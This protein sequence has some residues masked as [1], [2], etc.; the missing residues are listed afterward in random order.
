VSE[1]ALGP[2]AAQ[3]TDGVISASGAISH[4]IFKEKWGRLTRDKLAGHVRGGSEGSNSSR[5]WHRA[6]ARGLDSEVMER[7]V[8]MCGRSTTVARCGCDD[9]RV[10]RLGCGRWVPCASC[11][12][13]RAH[14]YSERV[15]AA[16]RH[17]LQ[18]TGRRAAVYLVTLTLPHEAVEGRAEEILDAAWRRMMRHHSP[19]GV[20]C[21]A[22][23]EW[24]P[25]RD[26]RGHPHLH[27]V[28]V[29]S[30]LDYERVGA[31]W[32]SAV[33]AVGGQRPGRAGVEITTRA[34]GSGRQCRQS[35]DCGCAP[36]TAARYV[37]SYVSKTSRQRYAPEE[38][39]RL[40]AYLATRRTV[41]AS[42]ATRTR[43]GWWVPLD[44]RCPC[45]EQ[46]WIS[47]RTETGAEPARRLWALRTEVLSPGRWDWWPERDPVAEVRWAM[48]STATDVDRDWGEWMERPLPSDQMPPLPSEEEQ[49]CH[50]ASRRVK[51][52]VLEPWESLPEGYSSWA[53]YHDVLRNSSLGRLRERELAELAE[54]ESQP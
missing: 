8:V 38:W 17:H 35:A 39:A 5:R 4:D 28:L 15:S 49:R 10:V 32:R 37:A 2:R 6:R 14:H 50:L 31:R 34:G 30:W 9:L 25:G 24:T 51:P 45:C 19:W 16:V 36:C 26:L 46:R 44:H 27:V 29:A 42:V 33:V 7:Q 48:R 54:L 53:E 21:L 12:A 11:G 41:R 52:V 22:V 1:V 13:K 18:R 43:P 47:N 3:R 40:C 23:A 20:P